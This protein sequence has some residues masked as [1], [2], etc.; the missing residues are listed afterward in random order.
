VL[1]VQDIFSRKLFA[2]RLRTTPEA[3]AAFARI[4]DRTGRKPRELNTDKD[5]VF[6]SAEFQELLRSR[7]VEH[8]TKE[9]LNDISTID[10]AM[11]DVR[12]ALGRRTLQT[13][14]GNW[15]QELD[16]VIA[17]YNRSDHSALMQAEPNEVAGNDEL[18]FALRYDNA[19]KM[20]HNFQLSTKRQEDLQ[21]AGGYR[22]L[23]NPMAF[24][25]RAG[26][27][28]WS[29]DVHTVQSTEGARVKDETGEEAQT[30]L[31]QAVPVE[32]SGVTYRPY[33]AGGSAQVDERRRGV[34]QPFLVGLV[35]KIGRGTMGK[36]SVARF[37]LAQ[38]GF[39]QALQNARLATVIAFVKLFPESFAFEGTIVR[40]APGAIASLPPPPQRG[41]R[42]RRLRQKTAVP[43][44]RG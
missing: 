37:M 11:R 6:M 26:Q 13:D 3:T 30:K 36:K 25:R 39:R 41:A 4:L 14:G 8:R 21:K 2:E 15:A 44:F 34:L 22:T 43:E 33:A 27:P 7:G 10:A 1:L 16:A 24:R 31:V 19:Q 20:Q 9:A 40:L 32:S 12:G 17:G 38:Q 28:N 23:L 29:A 18:R 5:S 35:T 42:L